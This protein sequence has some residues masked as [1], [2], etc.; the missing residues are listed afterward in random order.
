MN[1]WV[2]NPQ[3]ALP[4]CISISFFI[5]FLAL[6]L[7]NM[8]LIYTSNVDTLSCIMIYVVTSLMLLRKGR[9]LATWTPVGRILVNPNWRLL[10]KGKV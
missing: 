10:E 2:K 4:I 6:Q 1:F 7:G 3:T 5:S 8:V 9:S